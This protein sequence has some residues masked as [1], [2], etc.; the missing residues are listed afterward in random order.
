MKA[1]KRI[2]C[3]KCSGKGKYMKIGLVCRYVKKC[4]ICKGKGIREKIK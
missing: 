4:P 1:I 2:K 3:F